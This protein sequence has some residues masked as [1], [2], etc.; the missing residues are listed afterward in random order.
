MTEAQYKELPKGLSK[1]SERLLQG[2]TSEQKDQFHRSYGRAKSVL[3]KINE[4][5]GKEIQSK[6]IMGDNPKTF[7]VNNWAYL[8]AWYAGYRHAMRITQDLTRTS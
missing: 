4:Y 1:P 6:H 8:Q 3:K 2:M 5:A 7:E